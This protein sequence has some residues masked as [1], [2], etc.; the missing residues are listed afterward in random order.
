MTNIMDTLAE[1]ILFLISRRL[2][3]KRRL[4][5]KHQSD[6]QELIPKAEPALPEKDKYEEIMFLFNKCNGLIDFSG[7]IVLDLGCSEGIKTRYLAERCKFCIGVD[8]DAKSIGQAKKSKLD[9]MEFKIG[10]HDSIPLNDGSVDII[11]CIDTWEHILDPQRILDEF[12]RVLSTAGLVFL[13]FAPWFYPTG[14]H[15][16][17]HIHLPW[18][19]VLFS[20]QTIVRTILKIHN[21]DF[22]RSPIQGLDANELYSDGSITQGYLNKM[23]EKQF[24][25]LLQVYEGEKK[26]ECTHY[27][28]LGFGGRSTKLASLSRPFRYLPIVRE[29]LGGFVFCVLTKLK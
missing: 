9:N 29:F 27:E 19:H 4:W 17:P 5:R 24:R 16:Q 12:H 11:M 13:Y 8:I 1:D 6:H 10:S 25:R 26:F 18:C 14:G 23:T 7:K 3:I 2:L 28:L 21:S 22:F 20:E 15:V